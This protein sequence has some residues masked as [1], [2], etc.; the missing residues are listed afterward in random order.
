VGHKTSLIPPPFYWSACT[1][2]GKWA[3]CIE[4]ASFYDFIL[5]EGMY[6][7]VRGIYFYSVYVFSIGFWN[8]PD[9]GIVCFSFYYKELKDCWDFVIVGKPVVTV[10]KCLKYLFIVKSCT[11][12]FYIVFYY[13]PRSALNCFSTLSMILWVLCFSSFYCSVLCFVF[14]FCLSFVCVLC[15]T[16]SVSRDCSFLITPS[17]FSNVYLT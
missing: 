2:L 12:S 8:C 5:L 3:M 15:P 9:S 13:Y 10:W 14:L 16:F 6:L 1:T 4:F 17:V 7:C 11:H